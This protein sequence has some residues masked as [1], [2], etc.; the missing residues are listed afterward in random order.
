MKFDKKW[1]LARF[2][3]KTQQVQQNNFISNDEIKRLSGLPRYISTTTVFLNKIFRIVD[4]CT[5]L[6]SLNEIFHQEIYKFNNSDRC[7]VCA[8]RVFILQLAS[9]KNVHG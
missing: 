4:P 9:R 6:S 5:F 2:R 8:N 3:L 7:I 1:L